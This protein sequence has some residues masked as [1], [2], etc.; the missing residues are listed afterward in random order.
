MGIYCKHCGYDLMGL[1]PGRCPECA[2]AFDPSDAATFDPRP[3]ASRRRRWTRRGLVAL[4]LFAI[5]FT[6]APRGYTKGTLILPG[7]SGCTEFSRIQLIAPTWI[8]VRYPGWTR[9]HPVPALP[10][11]GF[12][13][14]ATGRLL[15]P[16]GWADMGSC[17]ASGSEQGAYALNGQRLTPQ[18]ADAVLDT[19]LVPMAQQ[20]AFAVRFGA[21]IAAQ[22]GARSPASDPG[23][24]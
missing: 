17:S 19:I 4:G 5:A 24:R 10:G 13:L 7:K 8:P 1:T 2:R 11:G 3:R 21:P 23:S 22:P 14:T 20:K 9:R 6:F 15:T 18:N 12:S 16:S